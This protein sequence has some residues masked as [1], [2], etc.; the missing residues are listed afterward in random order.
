MKKIISAILAASIVLSVAACGTTVDKWD[1]SETTA[2]KT[3]T[4]DTTLLET[5]TTLETTTAETTTTETTEETTSEETTTAETTTVFTEPES[6]YISGVET[7]DR[8]VDYKTAQ[9][10][11]DA[12]RDAI[13]NSDLNFDEVEQYFPNDPTAKALLTQSEINALRQD[14]GNGLRTVTYEEAVADI[15]LYFRMLKYAYGA[16]YY[17]GGDEAF[18]EAKQ[19]ALNDIQ[20]KATIGGEELASILYQNL[21]FVKDSHFRIYG[22]TPTDQLSVRYE[23]YYCM[24]Q[25]YAKDENGYYKLIDGV[26]WYYV[27]CENEA[28]SMEYSL[29]EEG[30]IVYSLVRFCP[31]MNEDGFVSETDEIFLK[32]GDIIKKQIVTWEASVAYGYCGMD[33]SYLK[34]N[35]IAY[36]SV[37]EFDIFKD[38]DLLAQ[39]S[40]AGAD[41]KDAKVIIYDTRS[42]GGGGEYPSSD[43]VE[44]F[45]K[46][47]PNAR[48]SYLNRH[49]AL[50]T[51][52]SSTIGEEYDVLTLWDG[53]RIKNDIPI[54]F[55]TDDL[56][57]SGGES[58]WMFT[59]CLKNVT[60]IGSNT[61]G[62]QIGGN[63]QE[64]R[65]PNSKM[66]VQFGQSLGFFNEIKNVEGIGNEPDIWCNP[67]DA[68]EIA[69]K[70]IVT[71]GLASETDVE[72]LK[73]KIPERMFVGVGNLGL[74]EPDRISI[75]FDDTTSPYGPKVSAK[76][77]FFVRGDYASVRYMG[78]P[79]TDFKVEVMNETLGMI[80][81]IDGKLKFNALTNNKR[82]VFRIY[83]NGEYAEF[84]WMTQK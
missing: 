11:F 34:E 15:D 79:V 52:N 84:F 60:V 67:I 57:A 26:K 12:I 22:N 45:S 6:E 25:N 56:S 73:E 66:H 28:V 78:V 49:N 27:G 68:L 37:R 39:Y 29:D 64:F 83:Y 62:C 16:Y 30:H 3:T 14:G 32:N 18:N 53:V 44:S 23:Y 76:E 17:F 70:M 4:A 71:Q 43:W 51:H 41:V 35:G 65:L 80:E 81:I 9:A 48:R 20:G 2:A 69:L 54:F 72:A 82:C 13:N 36:I 50:W 40:A 21:L 38:S 47:A 59:A 58:V 7:L 24:G 75:F 74:R 5:T 1:S 8:Y 31:I 42:N 10:E 46:I 19:N 61:N 55:L 63:V 77:S 33:Y